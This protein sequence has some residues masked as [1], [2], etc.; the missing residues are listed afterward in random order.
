MHDYS[1]NQLQS[2]KIRYLHWFACLNR[3]TA[4]TSL[5]GFFFCFIP[6]TLADLDSADNRAEPSYLD[7]AF[8]FLVVPT[9]LVEPI[10]SLTQP[11]PSWL[12]I[13]PFFRSFPSL[14]RVRSETDWCR[15][16]H[17]HPCFPGPN[18]RVIDS[19]QN[20]L[21]KARIITLLFTIHPRITI[22][23]LLFI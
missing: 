17:Q 9:S 23:E 3:L 10:L 15:S 21:I 13:F 1:S 11:T 6:T 14:A 18:I 7:R 8:F 19:E 2:S 4:F 22:L 5:I 12:V 20:L 16:D